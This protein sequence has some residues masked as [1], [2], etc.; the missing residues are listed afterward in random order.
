MHRADESDRDFVAD[1]IAGL[2]WSTARANRGAKRTGCSFERERVSSITMEKYA[3]RFVNLTCITGEAMVAAWI[4]V[5]RALES[6]KAQ[7]NPYTA[8]QLFAT[9]LCAAAKYHDDDVWHSRG[10]LRDLAKVAGVDPI[11]LARLEEHLIKECLD[12]RLAYTVDEHAAAKRV[13]METEYDTCRDS[14]HRVQ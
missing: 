10:V 1:Q 8:H 4:Y 7:L 3:R 11:E 12:W 9:A 5:N 6:G 2:M 13:I 14:C